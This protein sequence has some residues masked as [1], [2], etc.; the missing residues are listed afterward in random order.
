MGGKTTKGREALRCIWTGFCILSWGRQKDALSVIPLI[1][2]NREANMEEAPLI[3]INASAGYRNQSDIDELARQRG[4]RLVHTQ[5]AGHGREIACREA[6]AGTRLLVACGGDGTI[7]EVASGILDAKTESTLGIIPFGTGN[8]LCRSLDIGEE[9]EEA[10]ALLE[11]NLQVQVD[12]GTLLTGEDEHIF[13]NVSSCGFSG[14]VDKHLEETDRSSWG[15]LSY[16]KSGL[17]ALADLQPF[18]VDVYSEG[19]TISV[20]ALNVVAGNGRYAASGIPVASRASLTDRKL[21]LVIYLGKGISDQL[22]NSRLILQ[23]KQDRSDTILSLRS[24]KFAM[25]FSRPLSINYDGELHD[26]EVEKVEYAIHPQR[27][28]VIV[29]KNHF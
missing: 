14:E 20:E 24:Q 7:H 1:K 28:R 2:K 25:K 13:F 9:A 12:V 6:S 17:S 26:S 27:L 22:F 18:H 29:G 4:F 23:G 16:L 10:F 15:T 11:E 5:Y 3:I 21:D 8:D 19:E